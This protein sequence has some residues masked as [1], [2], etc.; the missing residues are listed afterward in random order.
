MVV[1]EPY[2]RLIDRNEIT[3]PASLATEA[4]TK[5]SEV[6]NSHFV[7]DYA[8]LTD[9]DWVELTA[10]YLGLCALGRS[11]PP[12]PRAGRLAYCHHPHL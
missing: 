11:P 4:A 10:H 9:D 2:N 7:R 1:P 8:H 5:P 12:A 3:L 6:Q